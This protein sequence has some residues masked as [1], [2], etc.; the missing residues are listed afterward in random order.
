MV[1]LNGLQGSHILSRK[2]KILSLGGQPAALN[3]P[4]IIKEGEALGSWYGY[5]VDGVITDTNHPAQ[6]DAQVGDLKFRDIAGAPD[7]NN[8]PTG[9]DGKIDGNDRVILGHKDPTTLYSINNNFSYKGLELNVFFN[10]VTGNT[11]FNKTRQSLENLDGRRNSTTDVLNR[12]NGSNPGTN[13]PRAIQ[14]GG[15]NHYG[16]ENNSKFFEDGS[17]LKLR[18]IT[19]AYNLPATIAKNYM[20]AI[21]AFMLADRIYGP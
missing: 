21:Y 7:A 14:S 8:I 12:Y 20:Q 6:P 2:T 10:G 3:E 1:N 19:L 17:Y 18:N 13:I 11:I 15:T 9:P 16:S 4:E 5:I